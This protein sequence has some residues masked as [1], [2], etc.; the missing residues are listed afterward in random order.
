MQDFATQTSRHTQQGPA[1]PC[2]FQELIN[3]G[4]LDRTNRQY[5][6]RKR[7]QQRQL[8]RIAAGLHRPDLRTTL[9]HSD[10]K[11]GDLHL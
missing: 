1:G 11:T 10:R 3:S 7:G 6:D 5:S 8:A 2:G 4:P 9:T